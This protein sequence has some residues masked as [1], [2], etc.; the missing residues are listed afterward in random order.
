MII[1]NWQ[2][3]KFEYGIYPLYMDS[4]H[5]LPVYSQGLV[6]SKYIKI[7]KSADVRGMA[8][9]SQENYDLFMYGIRIKL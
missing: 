1:S 2:A 6:I 5:E 4:T 7:P 3:R 8:H 9:S